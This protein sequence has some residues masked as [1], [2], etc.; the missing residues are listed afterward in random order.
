MFFVVVTIKVNRYYVSDN[1][2]IFLLCFFIENVWFSE[3]SRPIDS[4]ASRL[5]CSENRHN[6]H[7][8]GAQIK[9]YNSH[10]KLIVVKLNIQFVIKCL[11]VRFMLRTKGTYDRKMF[12]QRA[13][14]QR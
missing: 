6:L 12:S 7:I 4:G 13:Q 8:L 9:I 3:K 14:D 1:P 5:N 2:F 11:F 10:H